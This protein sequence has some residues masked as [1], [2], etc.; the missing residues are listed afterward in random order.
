MS[1]T[2]EKVF[3][4]LAIAVGIVLAILAGIEAHIPRVV[5]LL[6]T[7]AVIGSVIFYFVVVRPAS[8]GAKRHPRGP[9]RETE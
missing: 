2:G 3:G 1:R 7:L 8:T 4:A 6:I 9:D 5:L